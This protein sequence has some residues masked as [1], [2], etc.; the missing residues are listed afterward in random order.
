MYMVEAFRGEVNR[1]DCISM[2]LEV[3]WSDDE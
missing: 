1:A 3:R 2:R